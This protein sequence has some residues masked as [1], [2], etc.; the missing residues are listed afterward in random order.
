MVGLS[1]PTWA[2]FA[3]LLRYLGRLRDM[4]TIAYLS[5]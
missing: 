4:S 5:G 2:V 1:C 3:Y